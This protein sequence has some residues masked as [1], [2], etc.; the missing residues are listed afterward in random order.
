MKQFLLLLIIVRCAKAFRREFQLGS[1]PSGGAERRTER[2]PPGSVFGRDFG[3]SGV[4]TDSDSR[5]TS[6]DIASRLVTARAGGHRR[7]SCASGA[8]IVRPD[9]F[10]WWPDQGNI[11][12]SVALRFGTPGGNGIAHKGPYGSKEASESVASRRVT[13]GSQALRNLTPLNFSKQQYPSGFRL[14]LRI[15][16]SG[17]VFSANADIPD[18]ARAIVSNMLHSSNGGDENRW[19]GSISARS[20]SSS[21]KTIPS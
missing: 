4:R 10:V 8:R 14:R 18:A 2:M 17:Y 6:P 9:G 1:C 20:S 3:G 5:R 15:P 7:S 11:V 13:Q 19:Q 21:S 12:W 16:N